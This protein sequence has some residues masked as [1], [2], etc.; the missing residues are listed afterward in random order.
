[1]DKRF[2]V[3]CATLLL[4]GLSFEMAAQASLS[5]I[6]VESNRFVNEQNETLVFRGY[7]TS[8]PDKLVYDGQWN[9]SYFEEIRAWGGNIVRFPVHPAAWRRQGKNNYLRLLDQGIRWA[10]EAGLYVIIDWHSIGNLKSGLFQNDSYETS[11]KETFEFWRAMATRY[12]ENPVVAFFELYNEP[13]VFNGQ[14]GVCSWSEWKAIN[15]EMITIIRAHGCKAIPLVAGF[16]WAYDLTVIKDEPINAPGIAYV[17]HPY[18][19]K[20]EK[21]WEAKWTADWGFATEKYPLIL[22]EIG[23]SG[24]EEA[25]A[26]IPVISDESYGEAIVKY[27]QERGISF[28]AWVFD[29]NWS[30]RMFSDWKFT[31]TRQGKF[32]KEALTRK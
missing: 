8:D 2:L 9:K 31:P 14:L 3:C 19:Q 18:P 26:H 10:G 20:R 27:C 29:A 23:F 5:R 15:E 16:N 22:T 13:T 24:P 7:N 21:P 1:M 12:K 28:V 30:P 17:S 11:L 32:F 4:M 6:R 25:G